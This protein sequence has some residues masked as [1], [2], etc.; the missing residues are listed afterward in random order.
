MKIL[1][2]SDYAMPT[3]GAELSI[4]SLRNGLRQC[5]HDARVFSSNARPPGS[6]LFA[7]YTCLGS[8]SSWRSLLQVANPWAARR[9]HEVLREF[10]PDIVHVGLFLTQLSPLILPLLGM[11]PSLYH[12]MWYRAVCPIGTKQLPDGA[13]CRRPAG[14]VC[15][16]SGCVPFRQWGLRLLQ[17]RLWRRWREAFRLIV[18]PSRAVKEVLLAEGIGPVEVVENGVP[19]RTARPPLSIPP[20]VVFAGRLVREKGADVLLRAF[21]MVVKQNPD[22]RLLIAGDGPERAALC[23]L[24]SQLDVTPQVSLL[25]HR[26]LTELEHAFANAW[27]QVVPSLWEEPFGNV[28]IEAMMRGTAVVASRA[29][30]LAEIVED[31]ISGIL[32]PPGDSTALADALNLLFHK[33]EMADHMGQK[34]REIALARFGEKRFVGRFLSLYGRLLQ[35]GHTKRVHAHAGK[36]AS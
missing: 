30:G 15:Y 12:A 32:V 1:L 4:L 6:E 8:L 14:I 24:A 13:V 34:G 18:A 17:L 3:G 9:L 25:G 23:A 31:H 20:V 29:G 28:A 2:V 36:A 10:R 16:R 5:G 11:T 19:V 22:A 35:E 21:A 27:V 33:Q 26:S 7:D